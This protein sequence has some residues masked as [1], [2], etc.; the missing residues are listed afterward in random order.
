MSRQSRW[1]TQVVAV[2]AVLVA[3]AGAPARAADVPVR[4]SELA[5]EKARGKE[6]LEKAAQEEGAVKTKSGFLYFEL[7]KGTGLR[8]WASNTVKVH[9]V[10]TLLDGKVFDSSVARGQ[11]AVFPLQKVIKCW[12]EGLQLMKVG[13]KAKL[14]CPP[15]L[16]YGDQNVADG[17][18]PAGSTLI[19]EVELLAVVDQN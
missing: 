11:P 5:A 19:F 18:I 15:E 14:V 3:V 7:K 4:P 1:C 12:T 9:Y 16:A 2:L 6:F 17:T 10:G 13:G 8:P